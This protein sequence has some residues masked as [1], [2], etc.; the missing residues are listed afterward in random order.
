MVG[1]ALVSVEEGVNDGVS[2]TEAAS[3]AVDV[4]DGTADGVPVV[5][6]TMT[7]GVGVLVVT[8]GFGR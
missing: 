4:A 3:V 6:S 7:L 8:G 1:G 5:A 2:V